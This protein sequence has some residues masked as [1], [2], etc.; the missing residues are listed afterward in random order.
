MQ[1]PQGLNQADAAA[2]A[3]VL[4]A[5]TWPILR[6]LRGAARDAVD[7]DRNALLFLGFTVL[8]A[9]VLRLFVA[10]TVLQFSLPDAYQ[11]L[12]KVMEPW[13]PPGQWHLIH[14]MGGPVLSHGWCRIFGFDLE[15][16]RALNALAGVLSVVLIFPLVNRWTG[17]PWAGLLAA[18]LMAV[19][20]PSI[21]IDASEQ[22]SS[23]SILSALVA[24]LAIL[25]L[26]RRGSWQGLVAAGI[27]LAAIA[28]FRIDSTGLIG[29]FVLASLLLPMTRPGTRFPWI[30]LLGAFAIAAIL[31]IPRL[32][33]LATAIPSQDGLSHGP[34]YRLDVFMDIFLSRNNTFFATG[35]AMPMFP[36]LFLVGIVA[37]AR[38]RDWRLDA[39]LGISILIAWSQ[40]LVEWT[41]DFSD[42]LRYQAIGWFL[43]IGIGG[44]G[45]DFLLA[46]VR[47]P[48]YRRYLTAGVMVLACMPLILER[49]IL[50]EPQPADRSVGFLTRHLAELPDHCQILL[51]VP[52]LDSP[53]TYDSRRPSQFFL[54]D[55]PTREFRGGRIPIPDHAGSTCE[56]LFKGIDCYQRFPV[57][58]W[59]WSRETPVYRHL[60]HWQNDMDERLTSPYL[61]EHCRLP[62]QTH[63][64]EPIVTEVI[65]PGRRTWAWLPGEPV[66]IGL[67]RLVGVRGASGTP[68]TPRDAPPQEQDGSGRTEAP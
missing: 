12:D 51:P 1:V 20:V 57:G 68:Q 45:A 6:T 39:F 21:R 24:F 27:A 9:A 62:F 44:V 36:F 23:L 42:A 30:R 61:R 4:I 40:Y 19:H 46:L 13:G 55:H 48:V 37:V 32:A 16:I 33:V 2:A 14:G 3:V 25:D 63:E 52:E 65:P 5:W 66:E 60:Y 34:V 35:I 38:K 11:Y 47:S 58:G 67:Y 10:D 64:L 43:M 29:G 26:V 18:F 56:V 28:Q 7:V 54:G 49:S 50:V 17:R 22:A 8:V 41:L 53:D 31:V 59:D 15:V